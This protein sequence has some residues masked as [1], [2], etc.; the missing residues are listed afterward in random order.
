[1]DPNV[2]DLPVLVLRADADSTGE[3]GSA[4]F[5][6]ETPVEVVEDI[7]IYFVVGG[8]VVEGEDYGEPDEFVTLTTGSDSVDIS[9]TLRSDDLVEVDEVLTV[10]LVPDP[11][12]LPGFVDQ[13]YELS[14]VVSASMLVESDDLPEL[15]LHG[16]EIVVEGETGSVTIVADQAPE[17]DTSVNYNVS[18]SAQQGVDFEVL[19]GT[20]ILRAGEISVDIPIRTIADDVVFLPGDMV[21]ARWPARVGSVHVDA[22]QFLQSGTPLLTLT[23]PTFTVKLFASP[24]NR[25][26]LDTGQLVTVNMEAGDQEVGGVISEIDDSATSEG[27]NET[28]EGVVQTDSDL[29]GVDGAVVTIDVVVAESV[30]AVVV[31]IA[32][33]LSDGGDQKVRVVTPAGVIERRSVQTGMLDGAYVEIVSG[34]SVGE[35]VILEIDRS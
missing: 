22:G 3:S 16:A 10:T 24:T 11:N 25:A 20:T 31:P 33:V 6:V 35:Y 26:K 17:V 18:G 13:A 15:T 4:G 14:W 1:M 19:T 5:T 30:D 2:P 34:L 28:Y 12:H 21:V 27:G 32:A 9:V 29:V 7:D 8:T 23:E